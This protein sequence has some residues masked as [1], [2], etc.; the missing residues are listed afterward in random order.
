MAKSKK[1]ETVTAE[2]S[3][4]PVSKNLGVFGQKEADILAASY[5]PKDDA[6]RYHTVMRYG[7]EIVTDRF[8][9][10]YV[11]SDGNVF[12]KHKEGMART[13]ARKQKIEVFTVK[14]ETK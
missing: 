14:I 4:E 5:V 1:K 8:D 2:E 10:M 7:N 13:H 9:I 12:T 3:A 6:K 11:T